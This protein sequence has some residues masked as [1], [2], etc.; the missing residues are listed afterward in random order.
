[1]STTKFYKRDKN[2]CYNCREFGHIAKKCTKNQPINYVILSMMCSIFSSYECD[3]CNSVWEK[4]NNKIQNVKNNKINPCFNC[5]RISREIKPLKNN[6]ET[7][8]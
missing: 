5:K 7:L 1:M 8:I 4:E 2:S 3:I 6:I